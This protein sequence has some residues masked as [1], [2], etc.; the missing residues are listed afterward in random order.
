MKL[1]MSRV[2]GPGGLAANRSEFDPQT[3]NHCAINYTCE[4]GNLPM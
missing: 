2:L 3:I 1:A 4:K